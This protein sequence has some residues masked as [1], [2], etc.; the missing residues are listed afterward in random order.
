MV[1][2]TSSCYMPAIR[3][4]ERTISDEVYHYAI[5]KGQRMF[6]Y[7]S[8]PQRPWPDTLKAAE[9]SRMA[10]YLRISDK[11]RRHS[12]VLKITRQ[13]KDSNVK[14]RPRI[15]PFKGECIKKVVSWFKV[16]RAKRAQRQF[17]DWVNKRGA[18]DSIFVS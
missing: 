13:F 4:L 11:A 3:P 14:D 15:P 7:Y 5:R 16:W 6:S 9:N 1:L 8:A 17:E 2:P 12:A 18:G 10:R